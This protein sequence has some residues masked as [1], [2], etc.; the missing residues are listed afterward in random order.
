MLGSQPRLYSQERKE[1]HTEGKRVKGLRTCSPARGRWCKIRLLELHTMLK[2]IHWG[3]V[4]YVYGLEGSRSSSALLVSWCLLGKVDQLLLLASRTGYMLFLVS[5]NMKWV[6]SPR[7]KEWKLGRCSSL[8][9]TNYITNKACAKWIK[10]A[11]SKVSLQKDASV[12]SEPE[13]IFVNDLET[14]MKS[15]TII[16]S[17]DFIKTVNSYE[18]EIKGVSQLSSQFLKLRKSDRPRHKAGNHNL[19][20][21]G[22]ERVLVP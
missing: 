18:G 9:C 8:Y 7:S 21:S 10:D 4:P 3:E 13:I 12:S 17:T 5:P 22:F 20:H 2:V 1:C 15:L 6:S 19:K 16:L 11:I 14:K